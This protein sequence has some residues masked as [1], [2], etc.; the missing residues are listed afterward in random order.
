SVDS[1]S[2]SGFGGPF[3][4][5]MFGADNALATRGAYMI[6][7]APG[8]DS[9]AGTAYLYNATTRAYQNIKFQP[10]KYDSSNGG[11]TCIDKSAVGFGIAPSIISDGFYLVGS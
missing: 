6:I 1:A 3:G 10:F 7:G 8:T 11:R 2:V 4:V 9:G 5:A